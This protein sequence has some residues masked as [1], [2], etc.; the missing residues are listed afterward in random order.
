MMCPQLV[1]SCSTSRCWI[2]LMKTV[3]GGLWRQWQL[4]FKLL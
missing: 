4:I 3:V 1:R 2:R